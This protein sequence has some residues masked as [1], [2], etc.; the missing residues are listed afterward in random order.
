MELF[1]V[2]P[3][4]QPI[5]VDSQWIQRGSL[6]SNGKKS[7]TKTNQKGEKR[8]KKSF[9]CSQI[10]KILPPMLDNCFYFKP[11]QYDAFFK[12]FDE[13]DGKF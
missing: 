2:C 12:K 13:E 7:L 11:K 6:M 3:K 8:G 1:P 4:F 5:P 10:K 9:F